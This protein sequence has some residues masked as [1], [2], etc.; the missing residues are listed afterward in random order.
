MQLNTGR[1][2]STEHPEDFHRT[3]SEKIPRSGLTTRGVI[4]N[5]THDTLYLNV[6]YYVVYHNSE[7]NL[8]IEHIKAQHKQLN[9]D[10]NMNNEDSIRVPSTGL[11]NFASVRGTSNTVFKPENSELLTDGL[12]VVRVHTSTEPPDGGYSGL[13]AVE[14]TINEATDLQVPQANI[15]NIYICKLQGNLLGQAELFSNHCVIRDTTVGGFSL[16]GGA[17]A[18]GLGRTGTHEIGHALGLPHTFTSDGLCPLQ[19]FFS[20]IPRQRLPNY[21]AQL[22]TNQPG[23][24]YTGTMDNRFRDC[25]NLTDLPDEIPPYAC[26]ADPMS[27][28]ADGPYEMFMNFMDYATDANAVMFTVEQ[29][30]AMRDFLINGDVFFTDPDEDPFEP[31]P[32]DDNDDGNDDDGNGDGNGDGSTLKDWEI[33]L[34]VIGVIVTIAIIIGVAYVASMG[35]S[36]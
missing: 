31:I 28:C 3:R 19:A 17:G 10:Y 16:V 1:C 9:M 7:D 26:M 13:L 29:C 22:I 18:Y 24:V 33:A 11:Y 21:D 4:S 27:T 2:C 14:D 15:L 20:D 6:R 8:P 30:A 23:N 25:N 5:D 12:E 35:S 34:I 32:D 36:G